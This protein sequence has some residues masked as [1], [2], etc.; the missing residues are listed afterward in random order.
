MRRND[1]AIQDP[2]RMETILKTCLCCRIGLNDGNEVYIV[3]VSYGFEKQDNRYVLYFH[4]AKAGRKYTLAQ[5][6]P[7][8]GFEMD[9]GYQAQGALPNQALIP[10]RILAGGFSWQHLVPIVH[11][12]A[13][14]RGRA[15]CAWWKTKRKSVTLSP[16]LWR[17]RPAR[18][19][20]TFPPPCWL[21]RLCF[22]W[23]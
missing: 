18:W 8:V 14:E 4:G 12:K 1:R 3:P 21:P 5:S 22:G 11:F 15:P 23:M 2:E 6:A 10:G 17:T 13:H 16:V 9:N 20:G 19:T 7:F